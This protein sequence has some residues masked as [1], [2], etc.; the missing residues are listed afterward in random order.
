MRKNIP[1]RYDLPVVPDLFKN[2]SVITPDSIKCFTYELTFPLDRAAQ[3]VIANVIIKRFPGGKLFDGICSL[4]D[5]VQMRGCV[6]SL[7]AN[8][9]SK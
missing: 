3:D 2:I 5:I 7:I 4:D 9:L 6:S 8:C 1:E